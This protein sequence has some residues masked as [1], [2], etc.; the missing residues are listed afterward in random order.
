MT[1]LFVY[2]FYSES[3]FVVRLSPFTDASSTY[4]YFYWLLFCCLFVCLFVLIVIVSF[5][6]IIYFFVR[7]TDNSEERYLIRA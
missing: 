2:Y 6:D 4:V 1:L 7:A 3:F 5:Y